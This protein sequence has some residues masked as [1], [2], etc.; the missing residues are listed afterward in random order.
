MFARILFSAC[1][2]QAVAVCVTAQTPQPQNPVPVRLM[3]ETYGH[4]TGVPD[5]LGIA[6]DPGGAAGPVLRA[7][8]GTPGALAVA[9]F[10]AD[11]AT[12][13]VPGVGLLLV[14]ADAVALTG[15][16]DENGRLE[17]P[18]DVARPDWVGADVYLQFAQVRFAPEL[19]IGLSKGLSLRFAAG[20]AQPPLTYAGPPLTA[21]LV[22]FTADSE[23]YGYGLATTIV[24]P[25]A[26]FTLQLDSVQST[27]AVTRLE[28]WLEAPG[29]DEIVAQVL[30]TH[31]DYRDF[32][33]D[34]APRIEVWVRRTVRG[35]PGGPEPELAAVIE[36][37]W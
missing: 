23:P 36:R 6:F 13:Q 4:T 16:F 11:A 37:D 22:Q 1:L 3:A 20:N 24:A 28:F 2:A 34:V 14:R 17:L 18:V 31:R 29:P 10:A 30:T 26:G 7:D 21:T 9:L 12:I 27:A 5:T 15:T 33:L 25:T 32:G 19:Q 8:G 35:E